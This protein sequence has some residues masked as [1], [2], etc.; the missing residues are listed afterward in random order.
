MALAGIWHGG[1]LTFLIFGLLHAVYITVNH[2][3]RILHP[4]PG[5]DTR[6]SIVGRVALTYLCVLV[7]AI[8]FRA[9]VCPRPS[10]CSAG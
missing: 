1:G 3:W 9:S 8:M 5:P 2:A 10:N 6:V 7:G 4:H